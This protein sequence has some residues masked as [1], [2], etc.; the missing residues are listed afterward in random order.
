[1]SFT[2]ANYLQFQIKKIDNQIAMTSA[3][4]EHMIEA[5]EK[6][7]AR[8]ESELQRIIKDYQSTTL[9]VGLH[10][11]PCYFNSGCCSFSD[12][13]ITGLEI[14]DGRIRLFKWSM[15][16]G[17]G[18]VILEDNDLEHVFAGCK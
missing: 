11:K 14:E 4:E 7:K 16:N 1:M 15:H 2:H 8:T 18:R 3:E 17:K 13:D 12:G 5:L 6:A 10:R 9:E